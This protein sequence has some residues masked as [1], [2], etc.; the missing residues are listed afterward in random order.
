MEK[1]G[2]SRRQK[3]HEQLSYNHSTSESLS[4]TET[5][6]DSGLNDDTQANDDAM[7]DILEELVRRLHASSLAAKPGTALVVRL[8]EL[9]EV[10]INVRFTGKNMLV[11]AEVA[12]PLAAAALTSAVPDLKHRLAALGW[13]LGRLEIFEAGRLETES[14][15][16]GQ[17]DSPRTAV[18]GVVAHEGALDVVL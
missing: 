2:S 9:G 5:S 7:V 13:R 11:R 1:Q 6:T 8:G 12:N 16:K 10:K 14:T 18:R 17:T 4:S 15:P 3:Q